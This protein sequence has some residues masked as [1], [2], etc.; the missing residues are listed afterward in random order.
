MTRT[1]TA[2]AVAL[3]LALG[4]LASCNKTPPQ[5]A[6]IQPPLASAP[7][8]PGITPPQRAVTADTDD[9]APPRDNDEQTAVRRRQEGPNPGRAEDGHYRNQGYPGRG[10]PGQGYQGQGYPG[11]GYQRQGQPGPD[12]Q[13]YQGQ[14]GR[15]P[16]YGPTPYPG[17]PYGGNGQYGPNGQ[18]PGPNPYPYP[19]S[20]GP[21]QGGNL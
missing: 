19:G 17:Q 10:Y 2:S 5:E 7:I 12:Y 16:A 4:A 6:A 14:P 8:A 9:A 13:G 20:G 15:G 18:P 21:P 3:V 1:S 11:Q